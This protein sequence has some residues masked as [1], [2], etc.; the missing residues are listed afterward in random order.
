MLKN[1]F[2]ESEIGKCGKKTIVKYI[3][4]EIVLLVY[5]SIVVYFENKVGYISFEELTQANI[6]LRFIKDALVLFLP[7]ILVLI[8]FRKRLDEIGIKKT[9]IPLCAILLGTYIL[10]FFLRG[11]YASI[12]GCYKFFFYLLLTA[13]G[14]ELWSRGFIYLQIKKYNIVAAV[15]ISGVFFGIGHSILPAILQNYTIGEIIGSISS[16]IGGGI[17]GGM[18]FIFY[19]EF[20]GS[21]FVPILIHALIDY[22]YGMGGLIVAI[23][24]AI[25]LIVKRYMKRK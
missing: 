3:I 2:D 20:S 13:L 16:Q 25:Y 23:V 19:L 8:W 17:V 22:S 15:I 10:F 5:A 6:F 14:E 24:T 11:D 7:A 12:E 4:F 1:E 18:I 9:E 21:I